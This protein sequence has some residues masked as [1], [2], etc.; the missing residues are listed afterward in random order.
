MDYE[1]CEPIYKTLPGWQEES[2]GI[3]EYAQL[4]ENAQNYITFI[5]QHMGIPVD[6]ISTGP[7]RHQNIVRK[8]IF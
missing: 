3:T 6:L 8:A 2:Y 5:E 7:E 1:R 4:P